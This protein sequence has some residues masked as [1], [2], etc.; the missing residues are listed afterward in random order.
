MLRFVVPSKYPQVLQVLQ[1]PQVSSFS[2]KRHWVLGGFYT[3]PFQLV[4]ESME[5]AKIAEGKRKLQFSRMESLELEKTGLLDDGCFSLS[6]VRS[7]S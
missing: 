1:A 2:I 6:F 7:D 3:P 5:D 4:T